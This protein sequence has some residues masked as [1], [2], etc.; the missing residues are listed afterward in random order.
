MISINL[1]YLDGNY[2]YNQ[3]MFKPFRYNHVIDYN[4]IIHKLVKK[5]SLKDKPND[6]IVSLEIYKEYEK[7]FSNKNVDEFL[8][9]HVL[10]N[11]REDVLTSIKTV[12]ENFSLKYSRKFEISLLVRDK[13]I[14]ENK[15]IRKQIA[16]FLYED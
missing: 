6:I 16:I 1:L 7:I 2:I 4:N 3:E 5:D 13:K 9:L 11:L 8:V 15:D 14:L 12:L 10:K